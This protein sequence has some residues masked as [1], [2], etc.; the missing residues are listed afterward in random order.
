MRPISHQ[1]KEPPPG[2]LGQ[3]RDGFYSRCVIDTAI[4]LFDLMAAKAR[5]RSVVAVVE[6][7][8]DCDWRASGGADCLSRRNRPLQGAGDHCDGCLVASASASRAASAI[9]TSSSGG[10]LN[11]RS[12]PSA[13]SAYAHA[14]PDGIVKLSEVCAVANHISLMSHI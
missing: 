1:L 9:P 7:D 2:T 14:G 5:H 13:L 8:I 3:H 11:P 6:P 12:R 10:S 4:T